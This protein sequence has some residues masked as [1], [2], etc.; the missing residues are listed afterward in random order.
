MV[1]RCQ[2]LK[3]DQISG[4]EQRALSGRMVR[5]TR[6]K[7]AAKNVSLIERLIAWVQGW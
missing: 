4:A 2:D 5:N 1:I 7:L 6:A 3:W